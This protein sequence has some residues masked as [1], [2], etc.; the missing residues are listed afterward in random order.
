M[1][2]TVLLRLSLFCGLFGIILLIVD[3]RA[4]ALVV[5]VAGIV[6][7]TLD[8]HPRSLGMDEFWHHQT[9]VQP[10]KRTQG[11]KN[12]SFS[13]NQQTTQT[14]GTDNSSV[15]NHQATQTQGD[16]QSTT[17]TQTITTNATDTQLPDDRTYGEFVADH[18]GP[19]RGV[20]ARPMCT[21]QGNDRLRR[22]EPV[23]K[24]QHYNSQTGR[25]SR[26]AWLS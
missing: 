10:R 20:G 26:Y 7:L 12:R 3:K 18:T 19:P 2:Q 23:K 8:L 14:E 16:T 15:S 6:F 25:L 5:A 24:N 11:A 21:L 9:I 1:T 4:S 13:N 22:I 17:H